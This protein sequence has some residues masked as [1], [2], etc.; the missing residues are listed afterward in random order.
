MGTKSLKGYTR[1]ELAELLL[2]QAKKLEASE[3]RINELEEELASR[4]INIDTAGDIA[5]AALNVNN[6]FVD[7]QKAAE[8]YVLN[9]KNLDEKNID[10]FYKQ[11]ESKANKRANEIIENAERKAEEIIENATKNSVKLNNETINSCDEIICAAKQEYNKQ[12]QEAEL[13][14]EEIITEANKRANEIQENAK[15]ESDILLE[16]ANDECNQMKEL[17]KKECMHQVRKLKEEID[18]RLSS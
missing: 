4:Q 13:K 17:C 12:L 11:M 7:A 14:K 5:Q 16:K 8:E 6:I 1:E 2:K 18:R 15:K 10:I 9:V 3:Q